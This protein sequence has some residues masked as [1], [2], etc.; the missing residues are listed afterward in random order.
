VSG[1]SANT[2]VFYKFLFHQA[3]IIGC[4]MNV[5]S[6]SFLSATMYDLDADNIAK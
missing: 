6:L 4:F 1:F 3:S 2:S 5:D